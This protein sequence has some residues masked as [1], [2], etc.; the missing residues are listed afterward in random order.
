MGVSWNS[1]MSVSANSNDNDGDKNN[2]L[3]ISAVLNASCISPQKSPE[4]PWEVDIISPSLRI[5][6]LRLRELT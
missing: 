1:S 5:R 2:V 3:S 6:K 4:Q